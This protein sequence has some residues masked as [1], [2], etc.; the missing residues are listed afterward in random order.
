MREEYR[1]RVRRDPAVEKIIQG[2]DLDVS[3]WLSMLLDPGPNLWKS[4]R[5]QGDILSLV[6][7]I[8]IAVEGDW[9]PLY[10]REVYGR[11]NKT[12]IIFH[13]IQHHERL[14]DWLQK[15]M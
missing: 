1:E 8:L 3:W 10:A 5:Y 13:L 14:C 12:S 11:S 2:L 6:A 9:F 15:F 7:S 4:L